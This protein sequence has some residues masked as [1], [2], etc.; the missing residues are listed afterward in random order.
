MI[1]NIYRYNNNL[2]DF[3]VENLLFQNKDYLSGKFFDI[4]FFTPDEFKDGNSIDFILIDDDF[5]IKANDDLQNEMI[6]KWKANQ[7]HIYFISLTKNSLN[8][9]IARDSNL[10]RVE[11]YNNDELYGVLLTEIY[12][13]LLRTFTNKD[14][15][16]VFLSHAKKDGTKIVEKF[17]EFLEL[18]TKIEGFFDV[19][20]IQNSSNW[21]EILKK[22]VENSLFLLFYSDEYSSREWTQKELILAKSLGVPIIGVEILSDEDK[23]MSPFL[24]NIKMIKLKATSTKI[25]LLCNDEFLIDS[26]VNYRK[27]INTLLK[28]ALLQIKFNIDHKNNNY[29]VITTKPDFFIVSKSKKD[30]IY[31]DPPILVDEEKC[32]KECKDIKLFTPL[33]L[34][35]KNLNKKVSVSISEPLDLEQNHIKLSH[36]HLMMS[37]IARYLL[38]NNVTL[39]YGGDILY[40]K[41]DFNFTTSLLELLGSYNEHYKDS[42]KLI[43]YAVKPFSNNINVSL[44]AKYKDLIDFKEIGNECDFDNRKKIA[45][46][47]TIMRDK[48]IEISDSKIAIGGKITGFSGFY[49]GVYEE[50]YLALQKDKPVYLIGGFGGVI[51]EVIKLIETKENDKLSFSYQQNHHPK[52]YEYIKDKK[53]LKIKIETKYDEMYQ[54]FQKFN[55]KNLKNGLSAK[56]NKKLFYSQDVYE[57]VGLVLKG[58]LEVKEIP[59]KID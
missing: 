18:N 28:E 33:T 58:L 46:N 9:I 37:E 8:T 56:E 57:I 14:K 19:L 5:V 21:R 17:K 4:F 24:S 43:N 55:T 25:E 26:N 52:L 7:K 20:D 11:N 50:V 45:Q 35:K 51:K 3:F 29:N 39:I 30:I 53:E 54:F 22:E 6:K 23:R 32:Y 27:I 13:D 48:T 10:I 1:I 47:L 44:K 31:P 42:K 15:M 34:S 12:H 49:P 38:I 36:L 40:Q 2:D 41:E 59:K 16:K